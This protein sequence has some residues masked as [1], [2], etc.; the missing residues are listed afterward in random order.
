MK[1]DKS[2]KTNM[3]YSRKPAILFQKTQF[4]YVQSSAFMQF[5]VNTIQFAQKT[6]CHIVLF[7]FIPYTSCA[8]INN[9]LFYYWQ[10]FLI[11]VA[12]LEHQFRLV[13]WSNKLNSQ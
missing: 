12:Q 11:L 6:I 7:C 5:S 4:V 13:S 10:E 2:Q 3:T 8:Q 9:F 1:F